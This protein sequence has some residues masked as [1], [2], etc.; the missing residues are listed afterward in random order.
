MALTRYRLENEAA[1]IAELKALYPDFRKEEKEIYTMLDQMP[2]KAVLH[3][4]KRYS[5]KED[6]FIKIACRYI[7]DHPKY[8]FT[9]DYSTITKD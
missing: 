7:L 2:P 3:W 9:E 5:G 8:N 4:Q 1:E 6:L